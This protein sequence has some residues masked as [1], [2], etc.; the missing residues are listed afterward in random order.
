MRGLVSGIFQWGQHPLYS[1]GNVAD[2]LAALALL[3]ILSF[4][5]K[6]VIDRIE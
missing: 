1:S 4:L 3:L 2:W 6:T 5:W